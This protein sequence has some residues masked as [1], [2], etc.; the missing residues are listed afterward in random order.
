MGMNASYLNPRPNFS[1][2]AKAIS[3]QPVRKREW[4]LHF[5]VEAG[6]E[7]S[8]AGAAGHLC[9]GWRLHAVDARSG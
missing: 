9:E 4:R 3:Y 6:H 5:C 1:E 2:G 7:L 8:G